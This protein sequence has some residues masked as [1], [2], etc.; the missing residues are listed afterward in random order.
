[1]HRTQ[2]TAISLSVVEST[3]EPG[4][5]RTFQHAQGKCFLPPGPPVR[6]VSQ[7]PGVETPWPQCHCAIRSAQCYAMRARALISRRRK[8]TAEAPDARRVERRSVACTSSRLRQC[9]SAHTSFTA[10]WCVTARRSRPQYIPQNDESHSTRTKSLKSRTSDTHT[11]PHPIS[12]TTARR[13]S[14]APPG[15]SG[16]TASCT[17]SSPSS[18][19][20]RCVCTA[21][22]SPTNHSTTLRSTSARTLSLPLSAAAIE[23]EAPPQHVTWR[24]PCASGSLT[25]MT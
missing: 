22:P 13:I 15:A 21:L 18:G 20:A 7:K 8:S 19:Y 6:P 14:T 25:R 16:L 11:H 5:L 2:V 9:A 12:Y 17:P 10:S 24:D 3:P 1:M 23:K 4:P